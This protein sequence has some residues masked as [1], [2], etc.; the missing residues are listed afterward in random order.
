VK[1]GAPK[2]GCALL[3][4]E[5]RSSENRLSLAKVSKKELLKQAVPC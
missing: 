3:K 5:K 4:C 2:T 1:K